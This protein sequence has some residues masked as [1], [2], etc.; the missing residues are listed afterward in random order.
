MLKQE[1]AGKAEMADLVANIPP[2]RYDVRR[3][4][5]LKGRLSQQ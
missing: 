2:Q 1:L 4:A 3:I 5:Y